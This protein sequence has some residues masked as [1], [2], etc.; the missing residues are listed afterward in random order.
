MT[1][2]GVGRRPLHRRPAAE[3]ASWRSDWPLGEQPPSR[4]TASPRNIRRITTTARLC[5]A[6]LLHVTSHPGLSSSSHAQGAY[7]GREHALSPKI[8][9]RAASASARHAATPERK[10]KHDRPQWSAPPACSLCL[11]P[12]QAP[13]RYSR[14]SRLPEAVALRAQGMF[15]LANPVQ[16]PPSLQASLLFNQLSPRPI[17]RCTQ[18][19]FPWHMSKEHS[20]VAVR[21]LFPVDARGPRT[22]PESIPGP[23]AALPQS[24]RPLDYVPLSQRTRFRAHGVC[25]TE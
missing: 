13:V 4:G 21:P 1:A 2:P 10:P 24:K 15:L 3:A 20:S 25:C 22:S 14:R 5:L 11:M 18:P 9:C 7:L 19:V 8:S 6:F 17:I 12:T 16:T 23:T